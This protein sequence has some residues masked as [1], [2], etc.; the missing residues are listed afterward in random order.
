[1]VLQYSLPR[2]ETALPVFNRESGLY[3]GH[4]AGKCAFVLGVEI[5][6]LADK[7]CRFDK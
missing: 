3:S 1:M 7:I 2:R 6:D 4:V 5:Q